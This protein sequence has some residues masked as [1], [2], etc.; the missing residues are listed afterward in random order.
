MTRKTPLARC[1]ECPL[2]MRVGMGGRGK[3]DDDGHADI[4]IVGE[5][6]G[7]EEAVQKKVFMGPSGR[8]LMSAFDSNAVSSYWIT[9]SSL[10]FTSDAKEKMPSALCCKERLLHELASLTPKIIV[11][12]G[13]IPTEIVL[14]KG[15]GITKRRG[16][17]VETVVE[18][19]KTT[20]LPTVH[21]AA[22]LRTAS[23][24]PDFMADF[25]KA[26]QFVQP[27]Q[28]VHVSAP[29]PYSIPFTVTEDFKHVIREAEEGQFAVFD[30]ETSSL[31]MT[32]GRIVCAVIATHKGIYIIPEEIVERPDFA[33][34][35]E[36]STA[37]WSA[38]EAKFDRNFFLYRTGRR[39]R[40]K[41]DS[42]L[43][44]YL[45]DERLGIHGLKEICA[46]EY[47]APDWEEIVHQY[48][49]Q[50][51]VVSYADVPR[52][53]LY[54]YA[55]NDGYWQYHLTEDL[56]KRMGSE[57]K[58]CW[59]MKH[60]LAPAVNALSDAE[61]RGVLLDQDKLKLLYPK[62]EQ[63]IAEQESLLYQIAGH[64]F[65]PR[66]TQQVAKVMYDELGIQE[67]G[68]EGRS[69]AAKTV[70]RAI[71]DHPFVD[72]LLNYRELYTVLTR[73]V[74][75]LSEAVSKDGRIHTTFNLAGTV[76]G[77][78]S[79]KTPNLQNQPS[80]KPEFA[81][82]IRDLFLA[83]S[84]LLWSDADMSQIEYRLIALF[85]QDPY[86]LSCYREGRDL[87]SEMARDVWGEGFTKANRTAAKTLNF[88][89]PELGRSK[90]RSIA[91]SL[92]ATAHG[93]QQPERVGTLSN[94][95]ETHSTTRTVVVWNAL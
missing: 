56:V 63:A 5:G 75:G 47:G 16:R 49:R 2:L 55:A 1:E 6:P 44:H 86:L 83:D 91:G 88:G 93:N 50:M 24:G 20:V 48:T 27:A 15:E 59:L 17:F 94:G 42:L 18:G 58:F 29:S 57:P 8:M 19:H 25:E 51:A 79:S 45:F 82:D 33:L 85:S 23:L 64:K 35:M 28:D 90:T 65:N 7:R 21:P 10:C 32:Q 41:F 70:L 61:T 4:I 38:H 74:K 54:V 13:N 14:G 34:A 39:V 30:I 66:S 60:L 77:R 11:T 69:T 89:Q 84:G 68:N 87:H 73:Y 26:V 22:V 71:D 72:A 95:S 53:E 3:V 81:K 9:N 67:V 62:Y 43:G 78:L 12:M 52:E 37:N 76:T 80:R 31:D 36:Q 40:I 46:R 92:N